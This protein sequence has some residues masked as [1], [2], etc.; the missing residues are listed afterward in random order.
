MGRPENEKWLDEALSETIGS[1]RPRTDFETWRRDHPQA[2]QMLTSQAKPDAER[3]ALI[4]RITMHNV[5][6]KLAAAAVIAIA[7]AAVV[8]VNIGRYYY[9]GKDDGGHHFISD[10]GRSVVTMDDA[11]AGDIEQTK[12]DLQQ[13]RLLSQQGKREVIRVIR[14]DVNGE[15]ERKLFVYKYELPD[16]RTKEMGE[17]APENAGGWTLN[18]TQWQE[19]M[20]LKKAGPGDDL[21]TY[22]EQVMGRTFEFKRQR[23][24]LSDG[25]EVVWIIGEPQSAP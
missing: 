11:D 2:V 12:S 10:D 14:T 25:T 22:T 21:G 3:P 23:Y 18:D 24:V 4:R 19:M 9:M 20:R 17:A 16:G 6:T 7:A 13:M 5:K 15:L 8:G 1:K